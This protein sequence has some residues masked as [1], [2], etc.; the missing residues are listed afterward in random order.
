MSGR[1]GGGSARTVGFDGRSA[2]F[3]QFKADGA[4]IY[5]SIAKRYVEHVVDNNLTFFSSVS[6]QCIHVTSLLYRISKSAHRTSMY[7]VGGTGRSRIAGH[8]GCVRALERRPA[9]WTGQ[10]RHLFYLH[11]RA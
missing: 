3:I 4:G 6:M 11:L 2:S 9:G 10:E 1:G 5:L 8:T 7:V